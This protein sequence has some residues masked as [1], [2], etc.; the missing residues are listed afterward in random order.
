MID[1]HGPSL[2]VY[3]VN[4]DGGKE[5]LREV[6]WVFAL[7]KEDEGK[8]DWEVEVSAMAARPAGDEA[9]GELEAEFTGIEVNWD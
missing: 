9:L 7:G 8:G 2:W 6:C 4:K 5:S 1:H 3:A